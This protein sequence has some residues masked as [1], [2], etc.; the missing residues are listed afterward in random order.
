M[1]AELPDIK[2]PEI[3]ESA[4]SVVDGKIYFL[5]LDY[6]EFVENPLEDW[7]EM[8]EIVS[9]SS[10]DGDPQ[11]YQDEVENNPYVVHLDVYVH[12][13]TMWGVSGDLDYVPGVEF[14]WDGVRSAGVW[15][16]DEDTLSDALKLKDDERSA[17]LRKRAEEA[18][19]VYNQ[20][21]NGDVYCYSINVYNVCTC[22]NGVVITDENH[23]SNHE[24][25]V[26]DSCGSFF[27]YKY[28]EEEFNNQLK[29]IAGL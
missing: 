7:S 28:A 11:R 21:L 2:I 22:D 15:V 3:G 24:A 12:S 29:Y 26:S 8:G 27:G 13:G 20:W 9:R 19:E 18:V 5:H 17:F 1:I 4:T 23:Y 14:Q 6:D 16:P 25:I 10:R